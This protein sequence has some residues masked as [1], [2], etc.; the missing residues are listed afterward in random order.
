MKSIFVVALLLLT[1]GVGLGVD[2]RVGASASSGGAEPAVLT[3]D[4]VGSIQVAQGG[5][6][7]AD[8]NFKDVAAILERYHCTVCHVG[9]E[10]R[11]GLRLDSYDNIMKGSED[12]PV[13]LP[14]APEKSEL[15]LRVKGA[16]EPRMPINGP[17]WLSDDEVKVLESWIKAGA[18]GPSS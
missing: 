3:R 1:A 17:P 15:L 16:K 14:G 9:A 10:P 13:V 2:G 7:A 8:V 4:S 11:D 6:G 18:K 5:Q 12:G